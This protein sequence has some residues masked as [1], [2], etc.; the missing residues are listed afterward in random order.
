M[1]AHAHAR[2]RCVTLTGR[3]PR[4]VCALRQAVATAAELQALSGGGKLPVVLHFW[5]SWAPMCSQTTELAAR[6][7]GE[8]PNVRFGNV[9]AEEAEVRACGARARASLECGD[10][11]CARARHRRRRRSSPPVPPA[12]RPP[13]SNS[14]Q[15]ARRT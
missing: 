13:P 2:V 12:P 4:D 9:E 7:A 1:R 8:C 3:A 14:L 15:P 10:R 5:A 11:Q 6:L